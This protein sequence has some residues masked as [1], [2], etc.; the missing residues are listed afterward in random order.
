L[1]EQLLQ[2]KLIKDFPI[3]DLLVEQLL[4]VHLLVACLLVAFVQMGPLDHLAK[5]F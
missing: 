4:Q 5:I 2:P 1:L 3:L